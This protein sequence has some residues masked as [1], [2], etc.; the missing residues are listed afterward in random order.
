MKVEVYKGRLGYESF[1]AN[2]EYEVCPCKGDLIEVGETIEDSEV[3]KVNQRLIG[4]LTSTDNVALFVEPYD[5]E[6]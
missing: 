5:W 6:N 1:L 2:M 3:Y 4:I